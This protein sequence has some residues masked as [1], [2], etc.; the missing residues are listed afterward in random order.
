MPFQAAEQ[1]LRILV[2][3]HGRSWPCALVAQRFCWWD[4]SMWTERGWKCRIMS[5]QLSALELTV[6]AL[7]H[8]VC[9][10]TV[11]ALFLKMFCFVNSILS[12]T[13]AR[14]IKLNAQV[15]QYDPI[16]LQIT[17]SKAAP[18]FYL[19]NLRKSF[20]KC[21]GRTFGI[22]GLSSALQLRK[23]RCAVHASLQLG[24]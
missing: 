1:H 6:I 11:P 3:K 15:Y 4:V 10:Y 24:A 8:T 2:G 19:P 5:S 16:S 17:N 13:F 12:G 18:D 21:C 9:A 14:R 20:L 7:V 23:R 22:K